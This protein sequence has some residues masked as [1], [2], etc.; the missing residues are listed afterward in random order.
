MIDATA[1]KG[2]IKRSTL[3]RH[4]VNRCWSMLM[5]TSMGKVRHRAIGA[6][7]SMRCLLYYVCCM[8]YL[9]HTSTVP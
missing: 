2:V 7:Q 9:Y 3:L 4:D 1:W 5:L 8:L 6:E